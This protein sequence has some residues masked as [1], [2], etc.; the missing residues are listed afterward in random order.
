MRWLNLVFWY[1]QIGA[2]ELC[3]GPGRRAPGLLSLQCTTETR[4]IRKIWKKTRCG[5]ET[6]RDGD[7]TQESGEEKCSNYFKTEW[8]DEG[9]QKV[10]T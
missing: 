3:L 2:T 10:L 4:L 6:R 9:V 1:E 5:L 8:K 7:S